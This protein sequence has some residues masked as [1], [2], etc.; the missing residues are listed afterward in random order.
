MANTSVSISAAITAYE[1][2]HINKLKLEILKLGAQLYYSDTDNIVTNIKLPDSLVS[3]YIL[4]ILK[5]EREL[6]EATFVINKL[7]WVC[8]KNGKGYVKAKGFYQTL[9]PVMISLSYLSDIDIHT[10]VSI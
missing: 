8:D 3:F 4:G 7:Y 5:L 2:I 6:N 10:A 9:S 1:K